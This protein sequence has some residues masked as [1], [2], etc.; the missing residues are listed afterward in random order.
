MHIFVL[1]AA[2]LILAAI[3]RYTRAVN[4]EKESQPPPKAE[5]DQRIRR[6]LEE[7]PR[8]ME[9]WEGAVRALES[10]MA[11]PALGGPGFLLVQFPAAEETAVV[12]AQYPNIHEELYLRI[13]RQELD[14]LAAAGVSEELLARQP[15]F[16]AE[17]CGVVLVS[18][19]AGRIPA[20]MREMLEHRKERETALRMLAERLEGRFPGLSVRV[21]GADLLLAP[22]RE[23]KVTSTG[24]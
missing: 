18:V 11:H 4:A 16:E 19:R 22:T 8:M 23:V 3:L 15:D 24:E 7:D 5:P 12:T 6:I 14:D 13:I 1:A 10:I 21:L 2:A 17:S 20:E 9:A